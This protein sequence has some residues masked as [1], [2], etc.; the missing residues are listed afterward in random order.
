MSL[1][2]ARTLDA[3]GDPVR[4]RVVELLADGPRPAGEIVE[5]LRDE[6]G[7]S[8]PGTSRHLRVLREAGLVTSTADAQRRVYSLA[9][10]ALR[11]AQDWLDQVSAFWTQRLDALGTEVARGRRGRQDIQEAP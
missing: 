9:P 6:R 7:L 11:D 8:Q 4:R 2:A 1:S 10:G 5:A 3:L